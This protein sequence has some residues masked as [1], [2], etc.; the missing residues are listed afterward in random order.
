MEWAFLAVIDAVTVASPVLSP[1]LASRRS[2]IVHVERR[3]LHRSGIC[4]CPPVRTA[5]LPRGVHRGA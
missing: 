4:I 5:A 3:S 2:P 1:R